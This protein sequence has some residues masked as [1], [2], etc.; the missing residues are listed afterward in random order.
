M[1]SSILRWFHL[2]RVHTRTFQSAAALLFILPQARHPKRNIT[3]GELGNVSEYDLWTR[4]T[5]SDIC[6]LHSSAHSSTFCSI[7]SIFEHIDIKTIHAIVE[8][9]SS[10]QS[11]PGSVSSLSDSAGSKNTTLKK[12]LL[13]QI[14]VKRKLPTMLDWLHLTGS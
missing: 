7:G 13:W 5:T 8:K 11:L 12:H 3:S 1:L 9:L 4:L 6:D 2:G 10:S 14:Q